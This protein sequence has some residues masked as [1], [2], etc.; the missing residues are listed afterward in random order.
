MI[1]NYIPNDLYEVRLAFLVPLDSSNEENKPRYFSTSDQLI[2]YLKKRPN[3]KYSLTEHPNG[4]G[5]ILSLTSVFSAYGPDEG[6]ILCGDEVFYD[7]E[8]DRIFT[9]NQ[10][11][12]IWAG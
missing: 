5:E 1:L 6:D 3:Q 4:R 9:L 7:S 2:S 11:G 10:V 12:R 8:K